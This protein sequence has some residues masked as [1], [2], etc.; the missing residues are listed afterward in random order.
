MLEIP[1]TEGKTPLIQAIEKGDH[2]LVTFLITLGANINCA[3]PRTNRTPLMIALFHGR[4]EIVNTLIEKG[5]NPDLTDIN[6]LNA[7]HYAVDANDLSSVETALLYVPNV[8]C[9]DNKGW[10]PLLRAG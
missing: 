2:Q 7:L 3:I 6:G 9:P 10:T 5:A 8:D 1:N 4:I